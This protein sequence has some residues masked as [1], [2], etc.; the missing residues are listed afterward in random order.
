MSHLNLVIKEVFEIDLTSKSNYILLTQNE[1]SSKNSALTVMKKLLS[2]LNKETL[3]LLDYTQW[4]VL[5]EM[6]TDFP[7]HDISNAMGKVC[8]M[9]AENDL[10]FGTRINETLAI[11]QIQITVVIYPLK[12]HSDE[13]N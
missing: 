8:D 7:L 12:D 3:M 10:T 11:E 5:F 2:L 6:H 13:K 1:S 4:Y 9:S